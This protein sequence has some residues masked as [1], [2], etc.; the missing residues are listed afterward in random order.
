[1]AASRMRVLVNAREGDVAVRALL[2]AD[3][4]YIDRANG[5]PVVVKMTMLVVTTVA[6]GCWISSAGNIMLRFTR[7]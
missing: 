6:L 1:M 2:H 7:A 4:T 5:S 3:G